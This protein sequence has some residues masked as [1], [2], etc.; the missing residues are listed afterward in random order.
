LQLLIVLVLLFY[1]LPFAIIAATTGWRSLVVT[2]SLE[3]I[4]LA[5]LWY[6]NLRY[7]G[8]GF[9][10]G[11]ADMAIFMFSASFAAASI[12]RSLTLFG[13]TGARWRTPIVLLA[14]FLA[15]PALYFG[16][17]AYGTLRRIH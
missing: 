7:H 13:N 15:P 12:G 9:G 10:Q 8:D 4:V 3:A 5:W 11:M 1:V 17:A 14:S 2:T 6:N 16:L